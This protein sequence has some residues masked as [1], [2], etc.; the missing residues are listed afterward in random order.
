MRVL[1][2]KVPKTVNSSFLVQTDDEPHFYDILHKHP[3]VQLTAI[4]ESEGTV[5]IGDYVGS[6]KPGDVFLINKNVP[7]VFKNDKKYY[8]G[9]PDL[10]GYGVSVFF[11][12]H[13]F[14]DKFFKL[15]ETQHIGE[16]LRKRH[17]IKLNQEFAALL[18]PKIVALRDKSGVSGVIELLSILEILCDADARSTTL[19]AELLHDITESQAKRLNDIYQFTMNE[20]NREISLE[21]IADVANM[22]VPS[23]CRYFKKRTRKTY[24]EFLTEIRISHAC[25]MLQK[26]DI[27]ITGIS[28]LSGFNNLSNFNRKFKKITGYTPSGFRK[29]NFSI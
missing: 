11:D 23:F 5:L 14:G 7:H 13:V 12:E 24:I 15:P 17:S 26:E 22:T 1:P 8:E 9:N 10:R 28:H 18:L 21:E 16:F 29:V 2:F 25:K 4:I 3:E 19:A 20:F 6:F 27:S